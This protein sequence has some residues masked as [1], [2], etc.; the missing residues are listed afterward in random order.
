MKKALA[1]ITIIGGASSSAGPAVAPSRS[2]AEGEENCKILD[3]ST[4]I[5]AAIRLRWVPS[6]Q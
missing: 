6:K 2:L 4:A 5:L 1:W 3:T